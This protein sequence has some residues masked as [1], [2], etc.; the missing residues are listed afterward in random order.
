MRNGF[1]AAAILGLSSGSALAQSQTASLTV[2]GTRLEIDASA[3]VA[4]VPDL[5]TISAGV[6]SRAATASAAF[7]DSADRRQRVITAL[8][9]AGI[10]DRDIQTGSI[11]LNP[12]FRYPPNEAPQIVGYTASNMLS[13][14]FRDVRSSGR[15]LDALVAQGANQINGPSFSI[16]HPEEALDEA[17]QKALALGRARAERYAH[18]LGMRSI[19]LVGVSEGGGGYLGPTPMVF[20][21]A[22]TRVQPGEENLQVSM[23]LT[24]ELQ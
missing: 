19:R 8:K 2:N 20:A 3:N 5:V 12:E 11:S 14:R 23:H 1:L 16:E 6:V 15:I 7:Q 17:R 24:F 22:E 21:K 13:V 10:E 18:W 4:R 9:H